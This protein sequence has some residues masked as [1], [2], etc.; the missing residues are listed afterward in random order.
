MKAQAFTEYLII[1][2]VSMSVDEALELYTVAE[3]AQSPVGDALTLT[4]IVTKLEDQTCTQ[5]ATFTIARLSVVS[6]VKAQ[7]VGNVLRLNDGEEEAVLDSCFTGQRNSIAVGV[8]LAPD[9]T[10]LP[11][12][13]LKKLPRGASIINSA[14]GETKAAIA[15][16][17]YQDYDL[18]GSK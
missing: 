13:L 9:S 2:V 15:I 11:F 14:T 6:T 16:P 12:G 18:G 8:S 4:Y 3:P 5:A 7:V 1:A 17:A 10:E